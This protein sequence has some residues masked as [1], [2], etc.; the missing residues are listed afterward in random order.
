M[1]VGG[2]SHVQTIDW[3]ILTTAFGESLLSLIAS[4]QANQLAHKTVLLQALNS[5]QARSNL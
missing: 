3:I 5:R 4:A 1:G 2:R